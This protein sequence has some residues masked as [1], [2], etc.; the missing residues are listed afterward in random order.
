MLP[1]PPVLSLGAS[2]E[3]SQ[4]LNPPPPPPPLLEEAP[5]QVTQHQ[6]WGGAGRQSGLG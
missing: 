4:G 6:S 1:N 3:G 2:L 5:H